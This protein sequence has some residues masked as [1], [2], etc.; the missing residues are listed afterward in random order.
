MV[1]EPASTIGPSITS[2]FPPTSRAPFSQ[3]RARPSCHGSLQEP[4]H[5]IEE[6]SEG[7]QESRRRDYPGERLY[8]PEKIRRLKPMSLR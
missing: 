3:P 1:N 4:R 8:G 7:L 6:S 2:N 5:L